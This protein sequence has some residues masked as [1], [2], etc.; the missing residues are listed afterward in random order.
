P[1]WSDWLGV[2]LCVVGASVVLF[3]PRLSQ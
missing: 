3:G 2:A 1:L